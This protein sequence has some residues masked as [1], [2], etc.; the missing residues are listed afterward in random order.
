MVNPAIDISALSVAYGETTVLNGI[1][2][3]VAKGEIAIVLGGSGCGKS[4]LLKSIIG[5]VQPR[6]GRIEVLGQDATDLDEETRTALTRQFGVMFQYGALFN[7]LTIGQNIALPLEMHTD[8]TPDLIAD[9]VRTRLSLV[10]LEHAYDRY[11]DEL[12]GG[13]RK[14]AAL[15]RAMVMD[16]KI[17]F[18]DEPG[19][20]LD[21]VTAAE[22]D[23]LLLTINRALGTTIIIVT[24]ELLSIERLDGRL[25]MLDQGKVIF[26]GTVSEAKDSVHPFIHPFFHPG[27]PHA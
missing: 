11:P 20:G 4:T 16:P 14:R 24:H 5:L 15:S 9:I 3:Q 26:T 8:L 25:I 13:M 12:S 2:V 7:S 18:C 21:P 22:I 10:G 27:D 23:E 19:A 1:D 17:L 6:T